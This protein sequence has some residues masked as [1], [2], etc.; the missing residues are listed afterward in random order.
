M[1]QDNTINCVLPDRNKLK[2][3]AARHVGFIIE[4]YKNSGQESLGIYSWE[5][6][7]IC[8]F[9]KLDAT[10]LI[11]KNGLTEAGLRIIRASEQEVIIGKL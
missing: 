4:D 6:K 9:S 8:L 1:M 5:A 2:T 10:K 3:T 11:V 7:A